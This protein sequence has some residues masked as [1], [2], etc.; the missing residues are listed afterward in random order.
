M[1]EGV[2]NLGRVETALLKRVRVLAAGDRAP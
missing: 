1:Q 2:A